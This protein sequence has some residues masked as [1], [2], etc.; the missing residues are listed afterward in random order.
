MKQIKFLAI[1]LLGGSFALTSCG[2]NDCNHDEYINKIKKLEEEAA[3]AKKKEKEE[4]EKEAKGTVEIKTVAQGSQDNPAKQTGDFVK[5][6]FKE[7]KVVTGDDW[8]FAIRG[9]LIITNGR[10]KNGQSAGL[11]FGAT[12]PERTK[13]VKVISALGKF[14]DITSIGGFVGTQWHMDYD[15]AMGHGN[16]LM[17]AISFASSTSSIGQTRQPWHLRASKDR[18]KKLL[19]RPVVFIFQTQDG[20]VAKMVIKK[21]E[22]TN[23]DFD[24]KEEI[25]YTF[26]YYYNPKAGS[27]SLD[28]TK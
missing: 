12:E 2:D 26:K 19:L 7:G 21:M 9:R 15:Y 1:L 28:E 16:E 8:D 3:A 13:E 5:F 23:T 17:P 14:E 4:K 10:S 25:T 11:V 20:S 18:G 27:T 24:V 22:R 6:S